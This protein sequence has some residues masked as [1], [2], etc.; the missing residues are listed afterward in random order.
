VSYLAKVVGDIEV[1]SIEGIRLCFEHG[2]SPNDHSNNEPLIYELI[3]KYLRGPQFKEVSKTVS[4]LVKA[5][6]GFD[7]PPANVP[8]EYLKHP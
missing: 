1:H 8:N 5:A 3:S 7:Y 6:Y 2:V 4:K